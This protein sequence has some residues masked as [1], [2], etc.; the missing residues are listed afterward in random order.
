MPVV[1]CRLKKGEEQLQLK[2]LYKRSLELQNQLRD[3]SV[4]VEEKYKQMSELVAYMQQQYACGSWKGLATATVVMG[5][6]W[7]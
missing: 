5:G 1:C 4:E 6:R 3:G 2:D 7:V